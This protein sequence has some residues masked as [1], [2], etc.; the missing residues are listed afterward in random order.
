MH[1]Q[2]IKYYSNL[3]EIRKCYKIIKQV[4]GTIDKKSRRELIILIKWIVN[5]ETNGRVWNAH[6]ADDGSK[7]D[8]CNCKSKKAESWRFNY[9]IG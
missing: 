3:H 8:A 9:E 1:I 6:A 2:I 4:I 5:V 7:S